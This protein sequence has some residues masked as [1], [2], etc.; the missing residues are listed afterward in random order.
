MYLPLLPAL[1]APC[2]IVGSFDFSAPAIPNLTTG[3]EKRE[4]RGGGGSGS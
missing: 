1:T 4:T 2:H 3:T